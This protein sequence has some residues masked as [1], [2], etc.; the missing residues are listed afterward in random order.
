L[1]QQ[2]L[3]QSGGQGSQQG[4]GQ[5]AGQGSPQQSFG[6]SSAQHGS[7]RPAGHDSGL[8]AAMTWL[9]PDASAVLAEHA[10]VMGQPEQAFASTVPSA[11]AGT[12][13]A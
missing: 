9:E 11:L 5:S 8:N 3:G 6:G 10:C 7:V 1:A 13:F 12:N 4:F 2:G